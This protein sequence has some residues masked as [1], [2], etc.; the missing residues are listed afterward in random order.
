MNF[1]VAVEEGPSDLGKIAK[2]MRLPVMD[3]KNP[4]GQLPLRSMMVGFKFVQ[5]VQG[6]MRRLV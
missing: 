6:R 3:G 2:D 5:P 1:M 4:I